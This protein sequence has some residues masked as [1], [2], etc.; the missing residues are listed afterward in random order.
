M[1]SPS[2]LLGAAAAAIAVSLAFAAPSQAAVHYVFERVAGDPSLGGFTYSAAD[3]LTAD[4]TVPAAGLDSCTP[5]G[6]ACS[7]QQFHISS[8]GFAGGATDVADVLGFGL[9]FPGGIT[10]T[11]FHYFAN[12]AFGAVG[13]YAAMILT[14]DH[15]RLIVTQDAVTAG[16][17]EP[18]TWGLMLLGF[19]AA[20]AALRRRT[21]RPLAA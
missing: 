8:V 10:A 3:F 4:A 14:D 11:G 21:A 6:G 16:V 19:G 17:P 20:G 18:A 9:I 12:G 13:V 5:F 1:T 15:S 2:S 7:A